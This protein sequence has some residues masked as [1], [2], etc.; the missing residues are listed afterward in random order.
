M[1]AFI[2]VCLA[3]LTLTHLT[4]FIILVVVLLQVRRSALAVEAAAGEAH[5]QLIRIGG[6]TQKLCDFAGTVRS[7]WLRA[8]T[9]GLGALSSFW[10]RGGD[11]DDE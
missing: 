3:V 9:L 7:G 2:A 6:A 10:P 11:E 5:D 8:L 4:A 1:N